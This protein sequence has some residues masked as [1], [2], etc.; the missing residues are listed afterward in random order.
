M[1]LLKKKKNYPQTF[2]MVEQE[3][4]ARETWTIITSQM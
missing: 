4:W 2:E 3:K 1:F